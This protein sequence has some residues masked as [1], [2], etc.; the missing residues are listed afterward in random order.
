MTNLLYISD[1]GITILVPAVV[2]TFLGVGMF[3]LIRESIHS[4]R[5]VHRQTA[6]NTP[7]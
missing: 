7:L 2:W 1:L 5:S 6:H 4:L 3:E